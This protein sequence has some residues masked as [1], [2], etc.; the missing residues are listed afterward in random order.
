MET[1]VRIEKLNY[2][3]YGPQKKQQQLWIQSWQAEPGQESYNKI[4][5]PQ[6]SSSPQESFPTIAC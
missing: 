3:G 6:T 5:P 2:M 4:Q 1:T